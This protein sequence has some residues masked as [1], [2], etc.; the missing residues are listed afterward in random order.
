MTRY[1]GPLGGHAR[2]ILVRETHQGLADRVTQLEAVAPPPP[3]PVTPAV[4]V[5]ATG[6]GA[7]DGTSFTDAFPITQLPTAIASAEPGDTVRI[8]ATDT[9]SVSSIPTINA[10]H[11]SKLSGTDRVEILPTDA[12]GV[13]APRITASASWPSITEVMAATSTLPMDRTVLEALRDN[14]PTFATTGILSGT[15]GVDPRDRTDP[16]QWRIPVRAPSAKGGHLFTLDGAHNLTFRGIT[17]ANVNIMF[18]LLNIIDNVDIIDC[19]GYNMYHGVR[20]ERAGGDPLLADH[21]LTNSLIDNFIGLGFE[22]EPIRATHYR[23]D[24]VTIRRVWA[25]CGR[26]YGDAFAS[27][28]TVGHNNA[29]Y[30]PDGTGTFTSGGQTINKQQG[31]TS[32]T[33]EGDTDP[34][35]RPGFVY[36][37]FDGRGPT[38]GTG[39]HYRNGEGLLVEDEVGSCHV[40]NMVLAGF[41][42]AGFEPKAHNNRITCS[43]VVLWENR[44]NARIWR[45]HDEG[46]L[47]GIRCVDPVSRDNFGRVGIWHG[48]LNPDIAP[49]GS[50]QLN[51]TNFYHDS[52]FNHPVVNNDAKGNASFPAAS[53]VIHSG[54]IRR[55]GDLNLSTNLAGGTSLDPGV[56]NTAV[57]VVLALPTEPWGLAVEILN[58]TTLSLTWEPDLRNASTLDILIDGVLHSNIPHTAGQTGTLVTVADTST[59]Q[60]VQIRGRNSA[61]VAGLASLVSTTAGI[62]PPTG[63]VELIAGIVPTGGSLLVVDADVEYASRFVGLAGVIDHMKVVINGNA[64]S[65]VVTA[66]QLVRGVVRANAPGDVPGDVIAV[67]DELLIPD[68]NQTTARTLSF[69]GANAGQSIT[70]GFVHL[71]V[72]FGQVHRSCRLRWNTGGVSFTDGQSYDLGPADPWAG[73]TTPG[74]QEYGIALFGVRS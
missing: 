44:R 54:E 46:N 18:R 34:D 10:G 26:V 37:G 19:G 66:G 36:G 49:P 6:A 24:N 1:V 61:D 32:I 35:G 72:H 2:S 28:I 71:S 48:G 50:G 64:N 59:P 14:L 12:S 22:R 73:G 56:T 8:L 51:L 55:G 40:E 45:A 16:V 7:R 65:A 58:D 23:S 68:N 41:T 70:T 9:Y 13:Y 27:G 60:D 63:G 43:N 69:S 62:A 25:H 33:I 29:A 20:L 38:F 4:H 53:T 11:C 17:A 42:D 31:P 39:T 5:T 74:S 47:D 3:T 30:S 67:T 57:T 52:P 15:R 21:R